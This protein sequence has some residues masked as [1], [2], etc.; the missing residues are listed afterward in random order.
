V[1][2][3]DDVRGRVVFF[4]AVHE[5]IAALD[6]LLES[7]ADVVGI[8][9]YDEQ[10]ASR[11]AGSVDLGR[12]AREHGIPSFATGDSN[13]QELVSWVRDLAPDLIVCV[14]WTRLLK[15]ELLAVPRHGTIGFHASMLPHNRGRAPVNW[16]IIRGDQR[17]GNTM[18]MLNPGVDT[19]D[20]VD[21][22][23]VPIGPDD[24]C[25][26]VYAKV[27]EVGAQ[28]LRDHLPALLTGTAPR[29]PQ[30]R[31]H[32][33][34]LLPK[35]TAAMGITSF[36]RSPRE[37]HDWIRALT[38]PYPGAFAF[39]NDELVRLWRAR[40]AADTPTGL[41]P[42][43]LLG[44]DGA[45]VLVATKAGSVRLVEV[46]EDGQPAEPA[47]A[48]F[49]RKGLR[50]GMRFTPVDRATLEWALGRGPA[51]AADSAP[52][53]SAAAKPPLEGTQPPL[54]GARP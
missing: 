3:A 45:G 10:F 50:A 15:D 38:R 29:R 16:A 13:S 2:V 32:D 53:G 41:W 51:P 26:T 43:T 36:D 21:Q 12:I 25:A 20:I 47:C 42:G 22:R 4:G 52:S 24:T 39:L 17:A 37:V 19:G 7:P 9:T 1:G 18:M 30:P 23:P 31:D 49:R 40:P 48:W 5:A 6:A 46:Q 27:A 8:V 35:R 11:T 44:V 54:E 34:P 33:E 28:M 14:G